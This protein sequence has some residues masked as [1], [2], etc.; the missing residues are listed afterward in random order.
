M[1]LMKLLQ[2]IFVWVLEFAAAQVTDFGLAEFGIQAGIWGPFFLI[3][4]A[5]AV[6]T[7]GV[8][9]AMATANVFCVKWP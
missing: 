4:V 5:S 8:L 7:V 2:V 1:L 9:G 3:W 6:V